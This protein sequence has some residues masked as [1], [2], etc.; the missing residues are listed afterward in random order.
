MLVI[1]MVEDK[2]RKISE[3]NQQEPNVPLQQT[4]TIIVLSSTFIQRFCQNV[5]LILY[6]LLKFFGTRNNCFGIAV[7][8]I[9]CFKTQVFLSSSFM[10]LLNVGSRISKELF[11]IS[12][13]EQLTH[14][15]K[16]ITYTRTLCTIEYGNGCLVSLP[17][18]QDG[19]QDTTGGHIF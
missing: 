2:K 3:G 11:N 7:Q 17:V 14:D 18:S 15:K 19:R 5:I 4:L 16:K 12:D 1:G 10:K 8:L 13:C 9:K 6:S